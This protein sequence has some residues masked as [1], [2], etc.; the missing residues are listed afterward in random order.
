MRHATTSS[1][2][3]NNALRLNQS[4]RISCSCPSLN[5]LGSD[6]DLLSSVNSSP[7]HGGVKGKFILLCSF[8]ALKNA[9]SV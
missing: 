7:T 6:P 2:N 4:N 9:R 5:D 8:K 1:V 3:I